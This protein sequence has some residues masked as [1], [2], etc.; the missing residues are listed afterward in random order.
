MS[1]VTKAVT[2]SQSLAFHER[3]IKA[4]PKAPYNISQVYVES[5]KG[6]IVY[7]VDGNRYID[8]AG[9]IGIQN[10]RCCWE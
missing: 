10:I 1:E 9:G 3:R 4:V 6:A 7:D 2:R 5:A 8:F